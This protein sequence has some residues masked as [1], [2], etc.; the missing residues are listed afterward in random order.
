MRKSETHKQYVKK[1][2]K[3]NADIKV[4]GLYTSLT[5]KI[6]HQCKYCWAVWKVTPAN[7]LSGV[8][9]PNCTDR[10]L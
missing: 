10:K 1:A 2:K 9:C 3:V 7:I 6:H 4:I 5:T 8:K